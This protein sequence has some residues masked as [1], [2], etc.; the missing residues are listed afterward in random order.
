MMEIWY[1]KS[2]RQADNEAVKAMEIKG[3]KGESVEGKNFRCWFNVE[4][5]VN[6]IIRERLN[7]Q[8]EREREKERERERER[9]REKRDRQTGRRSQ[10]DRDKQT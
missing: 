10:I 5:M 3:I 1:E 9:E 7:I 2:N 8:R 6:T 4:I